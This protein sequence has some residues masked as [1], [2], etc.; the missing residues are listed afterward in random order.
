M[1]NAIC[2]KEILDKIIIAERAGVLVHICG[3]LWRGEDYNFFAR[4]GEGDGLSTIAEIL[5]TLRSDQELEQ[6]KDL[7]LR[8]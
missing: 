5:S 4:E 1:R 8:S 7:A 3:I 2:L 6:I